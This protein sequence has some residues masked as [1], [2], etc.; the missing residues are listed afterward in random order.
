[1]TTDGHLTPDAG[2]ATTLNGVPRHADWA[3]AAP[4]QTLT[5]VHTLTAQ[6]AA[7]PDT[8]QVG[9]GRRT[10]VV[11]RYL[12]GRLAVDHLQRVT[13]WVWLVPVLGAGLLLLRPRWIGLA[14]IVLGLLLIATRAVMVAVVRRVSLAR[15]FRPVEEELCSAVEAGK[16]NLR[17]E[18]RSA[19]LPNRSWRLALF[20]TRLARG[21]GRDDLRSRLRQVDIDRVLPRVQMERALRLLN[22]ST[23]H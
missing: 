21:S 17:V 7:D 1:M 6:A 3:A 8:V 19:G 10:T 22:K 5:S 18:L 13:R 16:A 2:L 12:L 23:D 15:R 20:A 11:L 4:D 9:A 14:V